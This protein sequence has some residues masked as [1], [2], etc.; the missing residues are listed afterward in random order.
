[1]NADGSG[2]RNLV[3]PSQ[4]AAAA[5][6]LWSPD[7]TKIAY[8]TVDLTTGWG[9]LTTHTMM[10]DGTLQQ[11]L[12]APTD[13]R[14]DYLGGWSNDGT[15]VFVI[16]G[17]AP[18]WD[19]PMVAAVVPADGHDTGVETSRDSLAGWDLTSEWAPD[20]GSILLIRRDTADR[21]E[22]AL[23]ID[24]KTGATRPAPFAAS[25]RPAWQRLAPPGS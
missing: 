1:M 23:L 20:D 24:P 15:S 4:T 10:A 3:E 5:Y 13:A 6:P 2:L 19:G 18:D 17:Y 8:A 25:S 9:W 7:G 11:A 21:P 14:W 16:R 12:P 22:T